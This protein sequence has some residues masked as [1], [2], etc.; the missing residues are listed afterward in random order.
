MEIDYLYVSRL[1]LFFNDVD[2]VLWREKYYQDNY[3]KYYQDSYGKYY[4]EYY[5]DNYDM[6]DP[7]NDGE[8]KKESSQDRRSSHEDKK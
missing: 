4:D 1:S 7:E 2:L 8:T 3:D 6:Y 5:E